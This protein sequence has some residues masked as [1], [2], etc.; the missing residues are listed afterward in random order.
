MKRLSGW[1]VAAA[2]ALACGT[3]WSAP[4]ARPLAS[5]PE[6]YS[7][8]LD[9]AP[10]GALR[11][12]EGGAI[13]AEVI[14]E[15]SGPSYFVKKHIGQPKY[16]D[17][18]ISF[19][20]G[21]GKPLYD[22]IKASLATNYAR[23]DG[24]ITHYGGSSR[25]ASR[26]AFSGAL[27]TRVE[28]PACDVSSH[29][30]LAL[31]LTISPESLR[32]EP[33]ADAAQ[34]A[35]DLAETGPD[36]FIASNFRLTIP[37]LNCGGVKRVESLA[38]S[39]AALTDDIGDARDYAKEP[40]K[41]EFPNVTVQISEASAASWRDWH[42]SFVIQGN[43]DDS[44]EKTGTLEYIDPVQNRTLFKVTLSHLG[45]FDLRP[46]KGPAGTRCLQARMY[47]EQMAFDAY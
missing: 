40:G 35:G 27:I 3:A 31:G 13:T 10:A 4:A 42:Q 38:V 39:Q 44:F 11:L 17:V 19:G 36:P 18:T 30:R 37:G 15:P 5:G 23:H 7:L 14:Q 22:W 9:G 8:A 43:N 2:M 47:C 16:E 32:Q 21:M 33:V 26:M 28:F 25:G 12:V 41:L 24:A 6:A 20:T 29:D 46:V 1:V 45:I 34:L